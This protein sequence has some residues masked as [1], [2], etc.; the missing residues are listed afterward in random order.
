[1]TDQ[2]TLKKIIE[3]LL[4]AAAKPLSL[5]QIAAIFGDE[6]RPETALIEAALQAVAAECGGR[7]FELVKVASGYR[8][9]VR[10]ELSE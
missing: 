3:G 5:E 2:A 4:L 9:Q 10:Q 1:M 7:G 8:F 6:E